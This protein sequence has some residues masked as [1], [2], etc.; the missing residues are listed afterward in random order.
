M[1]RWLSQTWVTA[2]SNGVRMGAYC[3]CR[4]S[5]G[6]AIPRI[7]CC[8]SPPVQPRPDR[9][10]NDISPRVAERARTGRMAQIDVA[11]V[12]GG[13]VGLACAAALAETG[14]SVCVLEREPRFGQG[15]STHNS[16]VIH[17]GLYY[18][19]GTLKG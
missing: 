19:A 10:H 17:A 6:T 15:T 8:P 12:G 7:V 2:W 9:S 13:V 16:G 4:S 1:K 11:V 3:A 5:S 18:P 14:R